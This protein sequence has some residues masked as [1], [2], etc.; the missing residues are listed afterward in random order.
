VDHGEN[1]AGGNPPEDIEAYQK[2]ALQIVPGPRGLDAD[3]KSLDG[4]EST[5]KGQIDQRVRSFPGRPNL[6]APKGGAMTKILHGIVRGNHIEISQDVGVP[7]GQEV[8]VLVRPLGQTAEWGEG[9]RRSAGG[10]ADYPEMDAVMQQ[11]QQDRKTERRSQ[12]RL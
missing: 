3:P 7:D 2:D 9:I 5:G 4:T 8:E 12:G 10:W 1:V 11:I 6:S